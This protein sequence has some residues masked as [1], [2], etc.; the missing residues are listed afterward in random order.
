M[1]YIATIYVDD[2]TESSELLFKVSDYMLPYPNKKNIDCLDDYCET[3]D[4][5]D[6]ICIGVGLVEV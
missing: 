1:N 4:E 5:L 2:E 3:L 6:F